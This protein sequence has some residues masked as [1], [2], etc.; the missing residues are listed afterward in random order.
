MKPL[1]NLARGRKQKHRRQKLGKPNLNDAR[2][3]VELAHEQPNDLRFAFDR[4]RFSV[5]AQGDVSKH[6]ARHQD[7]FARHVAL[8]PDFDRDHH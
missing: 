4:R 6:A 5:G 3:F 2:D 1:V 8:H 7:F